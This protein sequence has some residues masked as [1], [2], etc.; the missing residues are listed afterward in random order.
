[1]RLTFRSLGHSE[2]ADDFADA[3]L[4]ADAVGSHVAALDDL[5]GGDFGVRRL[6]SNE[7][8]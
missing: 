2:G 4:R 7:W 6:C 8:G 3:V 1:M 5:G